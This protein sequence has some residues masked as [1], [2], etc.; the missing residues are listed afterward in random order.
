MEAAIGVEQRLGVLRLCAA[1]A[2]VAIATMAL[3]IASP[4]AAPALAK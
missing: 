3:P 1:G 4:R 2:A